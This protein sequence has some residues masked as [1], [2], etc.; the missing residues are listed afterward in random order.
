MQHEN[1]ILRKQ[2]IKPHL[3]DI[4]LRFIYYG[5]IELTNL[6]G[7]DVLNLLI[8]VGELNIYSLIAYIQEYLI[9]HQTEFLHQNSIEFHIVPNKKLKT[10]KP[11][12]RKPNLKFKLDS[13]LIESNHAPLFASW[14]D[15]KESSYYDKKD[16]SMNLSYYIVQVEMKF[17]LNH[18]TKICNDKG[19][20]I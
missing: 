1:I 9:E 15:K 12:S 4:V 20:T 16:I 18:F 8:A 14:I 2:Y 3:F 6:Q 7:L 5:N 19:T 13:N 17:I 11:P 10:N